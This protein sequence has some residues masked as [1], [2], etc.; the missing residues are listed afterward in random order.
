MD[1]RLLRGGVL[2][3]FNTFDW[4]FEDLS[5]D[6]LGLVLELLLNQVLERLSVHALTT[7]RLLA[8]LADLGLFRLDHLGRRVDHLLNDWRLRVKKRHQEGNGCPVLQC[9]LKV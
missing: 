8:L 5:E 6:V 4:R 2:G 1:R 3:L 7:C 9:E